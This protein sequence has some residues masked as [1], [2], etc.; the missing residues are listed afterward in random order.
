MVFQEVINEDFLC[1]PFTIV[2]KEWLLITAKKDGVVNTMTASW[3]GFGHLWNKDVVNIFVRQSRFTKEFIDNADGF[4]ISVLNKDKYLEQL[5]YLG[6]V[7]GRTEDK[8]KKS[9]LTINYVDDIPYFFEANTVVICKKL[10]AQTLDSNNIIDN[11][12]TEKFYNDGD[13]HE[14]YFGEV[15]KIL[16]KT[17]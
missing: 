6:T 12:V 7:S 17:Q 3:G 16:K 14:L 10:F 4:S 2:G 15:T 13:N 8:I 9:K 1:N 5:R 11:L